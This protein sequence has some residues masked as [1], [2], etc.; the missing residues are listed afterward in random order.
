MVD[1]L[2]SY[3][4]W[5]HNCHRMHPIDGPHVP[6][7]FLE[8]LNLSSDSEELQKKVIVASDVAVAAANKRG[9]DDRK[10]HQAI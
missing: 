8:A 1:F 4:S 9:G 5:A 2:A 7:R 6:S 3:L 10:F